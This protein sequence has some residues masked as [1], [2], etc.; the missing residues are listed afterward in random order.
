MPDLSIRLTEDTVKEGM[1]V[2][3]VPKFGR[4]AVMAHKAAE[5]Q[6]VSLRQ[7]WMAPVGIHPPILSNTKTGALVR[8]TRVLAPSFQIVDLRR[9]ED[10]VRLCG[11]GPA[12]F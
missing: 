3:A 2:D 8:I 12:P 9:G 5:G 11:L 6:V 4:R 10:G 7:H 1:V